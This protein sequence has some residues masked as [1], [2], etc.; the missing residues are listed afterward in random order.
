MLRAIQSGNRLASAVHL[1]DGTVL[2]VYPTKMHF[3][4]EEEWKE[5]YPGCEIVSESRRDGNLRRWYVKHW[6]RCVSGNDENDTPM[7]KTVRH[8]YNK[9]NLADS[10]TKNGGTNYIRCRLFALVL[11][12]GKMVPVYFNGVTGDVVFY[13]RTQNDTLTTGIIFMLKVS[14][15]DFHI[16][17]PVFQEKKPGQPIILYRFSFWHSEQDQEVIDKLIDAG[18][19]VRFYNDKYGPSAG[20]LKY[21]W[22]KHGITAFISSVYGGE[23]YYCIPSEKFEHEW[24][25]GKKMPFAEWLRTYKPKPVVVTAVVG[26]E[27][28]APLTLDVSGTQLVLED[29]GHAV[30][31]DKDGKVFFKLEKT[32]EIRQAD[33]SENALS[34][35][36]KSVHPCTT[37]GCTNLSLDPS[38][39]LHT[40]S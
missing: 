38:C 40:S 31:M 14:N 11:G 33:V 24:N 17:K 21:A 37:D 9:Y 3:V 6:K 20:F 23:V 18:F 29:V 16:V 13:G 19:Y 2:Q 12:S 35:I 22:E 27:F 5:C 26:N 4:S 34:H 15:G 1:K 28:V 32:G 25:M 7:Q 36:R 30:G 8:F 10:I 39:W